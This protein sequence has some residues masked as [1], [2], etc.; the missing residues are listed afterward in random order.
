[1]I[2]DTY[3][4]NSVVQ[5]RAYAGLHHLVVRSVFGL[6]HGLATSQE[7]LLRVI[8]QFRGHSDRAICVDFGL[9]CDT[10]QS[11][12]SVDATGGSLSVRI[13]IVFHVIDGPD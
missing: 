7:K 9:R 3:P 8:Y 4:G 6:L 5:V 2:D 1:M 10:K 12:G 13:Q 11:V